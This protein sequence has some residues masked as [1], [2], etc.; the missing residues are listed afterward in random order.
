MS[1]IICCVGRFLTSCHV[2]YC[3]NYHYTCKYEVNYTR[4][5]LLF[6]EN[7][8][9]VVFCVK[10]SFLCASCLESYRYWDFLCA[11]IREHLLFDKLKVL[12]VAF[13]D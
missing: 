5:V 11:I 9:S 8:A 12:F 2:N 4:V 3:F 7:V 10:K 13:T 6:A 1:F